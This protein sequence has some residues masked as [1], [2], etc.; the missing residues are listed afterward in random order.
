MFARESRE[1]GLGHG[2][3]NGVDMAAKLPI[4]CEEI[5]EKRGG[6]PVEAIDKAVDGK[7]GRP[8]DMADF[9]CSCVARP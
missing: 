5:A 7:F 1:H 3:I 6:P 9:P 4:K 8:S 2:P